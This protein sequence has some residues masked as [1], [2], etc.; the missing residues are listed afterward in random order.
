MGLPAGAESSTLLYK[1]FMGD[2]GG[3]EVQS[4]SGQLVKR[5][6]AQSH[7][8]EGSKVQYV[9]L[10]CAFFSAQSTVLLLPRSKGT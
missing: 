5:G 4:T 6:R 9:V 3:L 10:L 8:G 1:C 2:R 7:C